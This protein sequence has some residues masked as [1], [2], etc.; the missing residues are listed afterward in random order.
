MSTRRGALAVALAALA[1]VVAA[2]ATTTLRGQPA[3]TAP[4]SAS[5][6][7]TTAAAANTTG[8]RV[9]FAHPVALD[10]VPGGG[11]VTTNAYD[12][13]EIV[14]P[15]GARQSRAVAG[16]A[17]GTVVFDGIDRVAYWRR[18]GVTRS[19]VELSGV[20]EVVVMN[21][22]SGQERVMLTLKDER[23]NGE[24]LWTADRR[25][26][27][28][29]VRTAPGISGTP[30]NRLLLV[31][32]D[33]G[34]TRVLHAAAGDVAIGPFYADHQIV[35]GIRGPSYV[36]LDV[37]TGAVRTAPARVRSS[38]MSEYSD[39]RSSADG[40]VVELLRRFE[41]DAGPLWIWNVRDAGTDIAK[42]DRRGISD[43]ILWPGR[44]EIVFSATRGTGSGVGLTALDYQ[45]GRTR[46]LTSPPGPIR[47]LE[48]D[49]TGRFA[50]V[51]TDSGMHLFERTGDEL[52]ARP[53]LSFVAESILLP[54]G[55]VSP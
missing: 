38:F 53:D 43:P 45:S 12:S 7:P 51:Q 20:H 23:S 49:M 29:S 24:L 47:V 44:A 17:V 26:L 35:A 10:V 33:T 25:S 15:G 46:P 1:A 31:D 27:V 40:I 16:L 37:I 5:A 52:K 19:P 13:F 36:V 42:V 54:L 39:L 18:A 34:A 28:V 50:L 9:V 55:I 30:Q 14:A 48:V 22:L 41:S 32:T 8:P 21:V 6:A 4:P 2:V 11:P 3:A